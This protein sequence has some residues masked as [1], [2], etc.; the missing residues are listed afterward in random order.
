MTKKINI[1]PDGIEE[2]DLTA[3]EET[4]KQADTERFEAQAIAEAEAKQTK[5]DLKASAK[6]KLMAGEALTEDEANVMI[7]EY[8][9]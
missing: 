9:L 8:L 3:E 6:A 1:T 2:L 5:E 7:G 4:Q